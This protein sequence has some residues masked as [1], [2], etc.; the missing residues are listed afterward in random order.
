ME[1]TMIVIDLILRVLELAVIVFIIYAFI[2]EV[3]KPKN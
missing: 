3:I 1:A 2:A